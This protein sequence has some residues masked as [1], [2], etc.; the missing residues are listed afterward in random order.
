MQW[1]KNWG[2]RAKIGS[3]F[4]LSMVLSLLMLL[5]AFKLV[6]IAEVVSYA[7][8]ENDDLYLA[9]LDVRMTVQDFQLN[10]S[11]GALAKIDRTLAYS[12][13]KAE[14]L[15]KKLTLK[16]SLEDLAL[17]MEKMDESCALAKKFIA[18]GGDRTAQAGLFRAYMESSGELIKKANYGRTYRPR[19]IFDKIKGMKTT[20]FAIALL[21]MAGGLAVGM[22]IARAIHRDMK[23]SIDFI[24]AV[25]GGDLTA[26][27]EVNKKDEIGQL[28]AAMQS[29]ADS[30]GQVVTRVRAGADEVAS[31]SR[32]VQSTAEQVSQ[33]ATEQ[34]ASVQE[35]AATIEEMASSIKASAVNADDGRQAAA[36]AT[37]LV[38]E[39]V[40][41]SR[42]MSQAM[43]EI[44][45]AAGRIRDIT[46]T[47]NQV[48]FQ[49][50]LLA[51]NAAVE[52]ARAG[53]HGKG[54]AVVAQEVRALAQRSADASREIKALIDATVSKVNAGS[55][56]VGK[57]ADAMERITRTTTEL[58]ASMEEIAAAS[59]EQSTGI[60]ELN[61]AVTQVDSTTQ[62][63]AAVVEQLAGSAANMHGS[64]AELLD[65][66]GI[67]KTTEG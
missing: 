39:N 61:R 35:I 58:S 47:V 25:S 60:D 18:A 3:G 23:R 59:S 13:E 30:L 5:L 32:E 19:I 40:E 41:L 65:A 14:S 28:A 10:K 11:P 54:F 16:E 46:D 42:Q 49:T 63:N 24:K 31:A 6:G 51:L 9:T 21:V 1:F 45:N 37:S 56:V 67:F 62:S 17:A 55:E 22:L 15:R 34:A 4:G 7:L 36:G 48:A 29:M 2:V 52:A 20:L 50:N 43:G 12:H 26:R 53:E 66:V 38:G 64:A 44:T 8:M 57:V 27:I 33:T